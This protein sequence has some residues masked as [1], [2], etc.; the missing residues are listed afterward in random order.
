MGRRAALLTALTS[1]VA[2]ATK[3][4]DAA[5]LN[6]MPPGLGKKAAPK[7]DAAAAPAGSK[8]DGAMDKLKMPEI[9]AP[10]FEV[11][12]FGSKKSE[13]SDTAPAPKPRR[14][15]GFS[16]G[17]KAKK[18]SKADDEPA[19]AAAAKPETPKDAPEKPRKV[20]QVAFQP[21]QGRKAASS[22]LPPAIL[23]GL[24]LKDS[25]AQSQYPDSVAI[26]AYPAGQSRVLACR[27]RV[28]KR[29]CRAR[30]VSRVGVLLECV[31]P[32]SVVSEAP[33]MVCKQSRWPLPPDTT[34]SLHCTGR[35]YSR[36][37]A[38]AAAEGFATVV[39]HA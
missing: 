33:V 12:K 29:E 27:Q 2:L 10:S 19:V 22:S 26:D 7:D 5:G 38:A 6:L 25:Q 28:P 21:M 20:K 4:A 32:H 37:H 17:K 14:Q 16:L 3:Q 1:G 9:K 8:F 24:R 30:A 15:T 18:E 31:A 35:E 13:D 23:W 11:P 36:Q 39:K 34:A